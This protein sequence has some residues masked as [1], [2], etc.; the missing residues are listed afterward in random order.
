[1][2]CDEIELNNTEPHYL[3]WRQI[4]KYTNVSS[5]R[6]TASEIICSFFLVYVYLEFLLAN[7]LLK[8]LVVWLCAFSE[9]I[10]LISHSAN[11][12]FM[13]AMLNARSLREAD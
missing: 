12:E 2:V 6:I 9:W 5:S 8:F 7:M 13:N 1:M 11:L 4:K 10:F 3:P